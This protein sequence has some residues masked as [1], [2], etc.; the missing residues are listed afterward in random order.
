M[1]LGYSAVQEMVKGTAKAE[2]QMICVDG[3][4]HTCTR[5]IAECLATVSTIVVK[6]D[7]TN[8]R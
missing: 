4:F 1:L 8:S 5:T 2:P 6:T 3:L 7:F